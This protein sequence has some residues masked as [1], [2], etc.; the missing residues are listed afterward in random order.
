MFTSI[1]LLSNFHQLIIA[2]TTSVDFGGSIPATMEIH[3]W[4]LNTVPADLQLIP[5]SPTANLCAFIVFFS[6]IRPKLICLPIG[7]IN[8]AL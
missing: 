7:S 4:F 3:Y 1:H 2:H 6:N 8:W 5:V